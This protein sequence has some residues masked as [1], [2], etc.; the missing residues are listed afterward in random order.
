M[1][2]YGRIF[3]KTRSNAWTYINGQE[4]GV[5]FKSTSGVQVVL[6]VD[7]SVFIPILCMIVCGRELAVLCTMERRI[8]TEYSCR[9]F[10]P[11]V[12]KSAKVAPSSMLL[13]Q[14]EFT[15]AGSMGFRFH[16][17]WA[18]RQNTVPA[19]PYTSHSLFPQLSALKQDTKLFDISGPFSSHIAGKSHS[20]L[21]PVSTS[22]HK[23]H[24]RHRMASLAPPTHP[25]RLHRT[26]NRTKVLLTGCEPRNRNIQ[27]GWGGN[28]K[29]RGYLLCVHGRRRKIK[30]K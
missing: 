9:Q 17:L 20:L 14:A 11:P 2:S 25:A 19:V 16:R 23:L 10:P 21:V 5:H 28:M 8:R 13:I 3:G 24:T 12:R 27:R 29:V 26:L 18:V 15:I 1:S 22:C 30:S 7:W 6:Y 4:D